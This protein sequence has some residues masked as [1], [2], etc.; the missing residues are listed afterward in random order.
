MIDLKELE[1][2]LDEA[3]NN[4][5]PESLK[6]WLDGKREEERIA[7]LESKSARTAGYKDPAEGCTCQK[8]GRKY[9]VDF[10]IPDD[11]WLKISPKKSEAGLLCGICIAEA[12]ENFNEH[13][14]FKVV[15]C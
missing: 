12:I 6:K 9:K 15:G 11:L 14:A 8:C 1:R 4:E 7:D 5:T 10:I 3:L 13:N 2:K